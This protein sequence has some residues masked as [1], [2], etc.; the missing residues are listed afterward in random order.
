MLT[1]SFA[2]NTLGLAGSI[3]LSQIW[4]QGHKEQKQQGICSS[5]NSSMSSTRCRGAAVAQ[6]QGQG[7]LSCAQ[8]VRFD[9]QHASGSVLTGPAFWAILD[10]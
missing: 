3:Y 2:I 7:I 10:G 9:V 1:A 5:S 8:A 4:T 6:P